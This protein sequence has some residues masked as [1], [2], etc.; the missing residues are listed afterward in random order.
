MLGELMPCSYAFL[1]SSSSYISFIR[2]ALDYGDAFLAWGDFYKRS[3]FAHCT[4]PERKWG[5]LVVYIAHVQ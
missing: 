3:S 2:I 1:K 5:L 4:I